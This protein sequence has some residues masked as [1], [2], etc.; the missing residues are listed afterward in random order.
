MPAAWP[1]GVPHCFTWDSFAQALGDGRLRSQTDT[2][3]AKVRRRSSAMPAALMG[4]LVMTY[5]QLAT[6]RTFVD[7]ALAGGSLPFTFPDQ[8]G[9]SDLLVRFGENLPTWR[10]HGAGRVM[11]EIELEVLP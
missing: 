10:R 2:G 11:V 5:A 4:S 9:G 8:A 7:S 3:P 1:V 6:L